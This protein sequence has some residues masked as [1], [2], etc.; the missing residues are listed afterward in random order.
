MTVRSNELSGL[1]PRS[2]P[3]H[4]LTIAGIE[5]RTVIKGR[6]REGRMEEED[7]KGGN[8]R[9]EDVRPDERKEHKRKA[10]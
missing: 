2:A 7:V 9:K 4:S 5:R 6:E 8:R 3:D 1:F 10:E